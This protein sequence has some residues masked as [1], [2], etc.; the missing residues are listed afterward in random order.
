M[1]YLIA[2]NL[3][4]VPFFIK[5]KK[6][7]GK[8]IFFPSCRSNWIYVLRKLERN[9]NN[10]VGINVDNFPNFVNFYASQE[11]PLIKSLK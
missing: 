4:E 6:K 1:D 9:W 3:R 7:S 10:S 2:T 8:Q 11:S 5:R